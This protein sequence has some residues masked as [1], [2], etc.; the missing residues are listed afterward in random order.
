MAANV[1]DSTNEM[2]F[3]Y[4]FLPGLCPAS[5]G[6]NVAKI[7]GLPE[8]AGLKSTGNF[9][10]GVKG[11]RK[12]KWG[13]GWCPVYKLKPYKSSSQLQIYGCNIGMYK[14]RN[15][16]STA[17]QGLITMFSG[18]GLSGGRTSI[19]KRPVRRLCKIRCILWLVD[20]KLDRK[21][22]FFTSWNIST[23]GHQVT[24]TCI[25]YL[26]PPQIMLFT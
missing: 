1:N 6:H 18:V 25:Y 5:H 24:L 15:V 26:K 14:L 4:K 13:L 22:R 8:K 23:I 12:L 20:D 21:S 19:N 3:L 11:L 17:F 7:A 2:T 9:Q 10:L 16:S